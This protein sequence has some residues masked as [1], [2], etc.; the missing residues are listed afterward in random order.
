MG[1]I[2]KA[3]R[4]R[5]CEAEIPRGLAIQDKSAFSKPAG[6]PTEL[7]IAPTQP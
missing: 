7:P 1:G 2:P 4:I 3:L 5:D 6:L